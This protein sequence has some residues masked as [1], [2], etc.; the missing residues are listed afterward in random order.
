MR[1]RNEYELIRHANKSRGKDVAK[2]VSMVVVMMLS[3]IVIL[4]YVGS[5]VNSDG[6]GIFANLTRDT[7]QP[8]DDLSDYAY[9]DMPTE[10]P[11]RVEPA[12]DVVLT[13]I[14]YAQQ[15]GAFELPM[16][17]ATGWAAVRL[18][19]RSGPGPGYGIL[20]TVDAGHG[21]T[22]L[23]TSGNWWYVEVNKSLSGWVD[24]RGCFINLPDIIPSIIFQNTNAS[25]SIM[26]SIGYDIP[27]VTGEILH[28]A[29]AFNERLGRDEYIVPGMYSLA[30]DLFAAQQ[31]ALADNNTIIVN[32]VF[33]PASAQ[34][35]V[36]QGMNTLMSRN[37]YVRNAVTGGQWNL[38]WFISTG[39]SNHQ[40]GAAVDVSLARIS[41]YE[42]RQTGDFIYRH[43][44]DYREYPMPSCMHEL[45]PRAAIVYSP[46]TISPAQLVSGDFAM[47]D[48]MTPGARRLQ[49]L[50]GGA[51]FTPLASE[52][53]HFNHPDSVAVANTMGIR[54]EFYTDSVYSRTPVGLE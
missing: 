27:G 43:V 2:I 15:G 34:S 4:W 21:F 23:D 11:A 52:W 18:P 37:N 30:R 28:N 20:L 39:V 6:G 44:V 47:T 38:G 3:A 17:G 51:G 5:V 33:R 53:W 46:T 40:R 12:G 48:S 24:H 19:V 54:G 13:G 1:R 10:P 45:S 14:N 29:R 35:A 41:T 50:F 32:E 7:Q 16:Y 8:L 9:Q 26:V 36:V 22:I 42:Y 49:V 31:A 25:G